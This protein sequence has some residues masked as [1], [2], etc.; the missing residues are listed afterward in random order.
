MDDDDD[1][2]DYDDEY[3]DD[4]VREGCDGKIYLRI[5]LRTWEVKSVGLITFLLICPLSS[6]CLTLSPYTFLLH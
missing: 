4:E 5:K 6:L 2:E 3:Y 1:D